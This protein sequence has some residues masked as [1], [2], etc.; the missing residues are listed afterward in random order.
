MSRSYIW[1]HGGAFHPV[2]PS[3]FTDI[4]GSPL[5]NTHRSA[6]GLVTYSQLATAAAAFVVP[7][8]T[9]LAL[10]NV[11][12]KITSVSLLFDAN[13]ATIEQ[14]TI[15]DGATGIFA[16]DPLNWTGSHLA[17]D[18]SNSLDIP[19]P[20]YRSGLSVSVSVTFGD[21]RVGAMTSSIQL[22]GLQFVL[23][24]G[25]PIPMPRPVPLPGL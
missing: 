11:F 23:D 18:T 15:F 14:I 24:S 19:S 5:S 21:G 25:G 10:N 12:Q 1:I 16:S 8:P 17:L 20:N 4:P 13:Q 2:I 3:Q 7:V 22:I 6:S 9:I